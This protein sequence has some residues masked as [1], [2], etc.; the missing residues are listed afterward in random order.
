[1]SVMMRARRRREP[2]HKPEHIRWREVVHAYPCPDCTAGPGE[3]CRTKSGEHKWEPHADR[4]R[5]A[6]AHRW[7]FP[8]EGAPT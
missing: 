3:W 2:Q 6:A 1:M 7:Q 4:S 8:D 5:L